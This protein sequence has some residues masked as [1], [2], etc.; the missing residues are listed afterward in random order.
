MEITNF[1]CMF[2]ENWF[3]ELEDASNP[4]VKPEAADGAKVDDPN[5]RSPEDKKASPEFQ[6]AEIKNRREESQNNIAQMERENPGWLAG[7][8]DPKVGDM[9]QRELNDA[10]GLA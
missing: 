9:A 8:S 1:Y 4:A 5:K 3:K 6:I 2:S 7:V 10:L